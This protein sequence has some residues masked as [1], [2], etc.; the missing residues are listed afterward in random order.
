VAAPVS[1]IGRGLALR[2]YLRL[3]AFQGSWN[4][5]TMVGAGLAYV[6]GPVLRA[7]HGR[8][9][10]DRAALRHA[11]FFNAHPYLAGVAAGALARMEAEGVEH[12]VQSRFKVALRGALGALGDQLVWAGWRPFCLLLAL[13]A[14]LLGA[15]WWA[16][17]G[18]FLGVYNLGHLALRAWGLAIGLQEG[19]G[20]A[21]R[22][23]DPWLS[24]AQGALA[25]AATFLAGLAAPLAASA[26][27]PGREVPAMLPAALL[28][29]IGGAAL[30]VRIRAAAALTLGMIVFVI[31][32]TGGGQ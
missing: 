7:V 10:A 8:E 18:G 14:A 29:A 12:E 11:R 16:V 5:E 27:G 32:L 26:F 20:V 4:Y 25:T 28:A 21:R 19:T 6:L 15:P 24:R 13:V 31:L 1:G 2:M 3:F 17:V 23:R 9:E 22:L 30:G